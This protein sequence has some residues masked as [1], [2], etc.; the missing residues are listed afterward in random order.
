MD[1]NHHVIKRPL[2]RNGMATNPK[3]IKLLGDYIAFQYWLKLK[4]LY[5]ERKIDKLFFINSPHK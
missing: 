5:S 2:Q 3:K 1:L 4:K